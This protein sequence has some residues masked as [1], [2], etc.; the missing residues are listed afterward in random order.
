MNTSFTCRLCGQQH[1]IPDIYREGEPAHS[2]YLGYREY[3]EGGWHNAQTEFKDPYIYDG[4]VW[5]KPEATQGWPTEGNYK[6]QLIGSDRP[7]Q[8]PIGYYYWL[9]PYHG[10]SGG[11]WQKVTEEGKLFYTPYI[12]APL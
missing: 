8:L 12:L 1:T 2:S 11:A 3:Y 6:L 5:I 10:F 7:Q 9:E 4:Y